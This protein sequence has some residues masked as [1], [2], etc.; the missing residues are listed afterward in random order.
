MSVS[1]IENPYAYKLIY[2]FAIPDNDHAGL[3]K[4]GETTVQCDLPSVAARAALMPNCQVLN[5][6]A[7]K[8]IDQYTQTAGVAY[9]L[10]HTE[11][12]IGPVKV[13]GDTDVHR[14]LVNSGHSRVK[15]RKG[16]GR[17]WFRTNLETV[18]IAIRAAKEGRNALSVN[19][20]S[21]VQEII[22]RPSQREAV[23]LA[24]RRF[25]AGSPSVLWNA[26]MRFG[27]TIAALMLA[28]EMGCAR[29]FILTHRPAVE[30]DWRD[31]FN[32]VFPGTDFY[33]QTHRTTGFQPEHTNIVYFTSLHDMRESEA[34]GGRYKKNNDVYGAAWDLLIVDEAHEGTQTDL[35]SDVLARIQTKHKL[36]LSGTP[37]NIEST[38][39]PENVYT[40]DYMAEQNAKARW[41]EEHGGDSNP[42]AGLPQMRLN[43]YDLSDYFHGSEYAE[44]TLEG[45]CFSFREFFRT[46][47]GDQERDLGK[48]PAGVKVGEFVHAAEVRRFLALLHGAEASCDFPFATEAYREALRHTVW[49]VPGVKE[50]KALAEALRQDPVFQHFKVVNVAGD[51]DE[52]RASDDARKDVEEAIKHH[53]YT[54]TLT[55]GR[56]TIGVTIPQWTG[57]LVLAGGEKVEAITYLQTIFRVQ[58]PYTDEEGRVKESCYVFDFAP[59]RVLSVLPKMCMNNTPIGGGTGGPQGGL[60]GQLNA[61]LKN[62]LPVLAFKGGKMSPVEPNHVF[63]HIRRAEAERAIRSGFSDE[64]IY[65]TDMLNAKHI[66]PALFNG[67]RAKIGRTQKGAPVGDFTLIQSPLSGPETEQNGTGDKSPKPP[68]TEQE[69]ERLRR[70]R[71]ERKQRENAI[72]ILRGISIRLPLLIYGADV[73]YNQDISIHD[74]VDL[75]DDVSWAEFMPAGVTKEEFLRCIPYYDEETVRVAGH[76][77]RA[78]AKAADEHA[79]MQRVRAIARVFGYFRNPDKETVLTPWRVVNRHLAETVGGWCFMDEDYAEPLDE[80]RWVEQEGIT[81]KV[82]GEGENQ[83]LEVN[84]KSGLYPLYVAYTLFRRRLDVLQAKGEELTLDRQWQVWDTVVRENLFVICKTKMALTITRRTLLGYRAGSANLECYNNL[85]HDLRHN[86][87]KVVRDLRNPATWGLKGNV[88]M[89]FNAIVGNPPYHVADGGAKASALPLYNLFFNL[90]K[91][92]EPD[93]VSMIMEARWMSGGKGLDAFRAEMLKDHQLVVLHDF[94][95]S[96]DCFPNVDIKGGVCFV[97]WERGADRP[98]QIYTYKGGKLIEVSE[99]FLSYEGSEVFLRM[100]AVIPII[101]K[102]RARQETPFSSI[103]SRQKPYGLR[104]DFFADPGKYGLPAVSSEPIKG[105]YAIWGLDD[106]RRTKCYI[107]ADYPLPKRELLEEVKSFYPRNYGEGILGEMP[108]DPIYAKP[109]ECCTETFIVIGPFTDEAEAKRCDAYLRTKFARLLIGVKKNTQGAAKSVYDLLPLQDF[110]REWTDAAL[111]EKYGLTAE[112]VAFIEATI[113]DAAAKQTKQAAKP[114]AKPRGR[115]RRK[116]DSL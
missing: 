3:L 79:P 97:L 38:F 89:H 99:R 8:R 30:Q 1:V 25:K 23:D 110:S 84:S 101:E 111:Y 7:K 18:K 67:L 53:P 55:C 112:E 77:I 98:C 32:K 44:R 71:E 100:E 21:H 62:F 57:A 114:D 24:K 31:D 106:K 81:Q 83:V 41:A 102:V 64:S 95:D 46:W 104:G 61:L 19:E 43:V 42:Y 68:M 72:A 9:T 22:L 40:W 34:V 103:V 69:K 109:G 90:A 2:V 15:P 51:G 75:V 73:D 60:R 82:F 107:P 14:V 33:F 50:A 66:D 113:P 27:K 16:A 93:Y 87:D 78:L 76:E 11:L 108:G 70:L 35:G 115:G 17:E 47:T 65:N 54:I 59:D 85:I 56:L 28:K 49:K 52:E 4:V 26:K 92:V 58:S 88:P 116:A 63:R 105:G 48:M 80:P 96:R 12:A 94:M 86:Q 37:Y 5:D 91:T 13:I 6:A 36:A 74:F 10:L 39:P 45:H 29:V 20:V